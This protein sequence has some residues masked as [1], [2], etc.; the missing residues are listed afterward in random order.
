[1]WRNMFTIKENKRKR[2]TEWK[3]E[4]NA[5]LRMETNVADRK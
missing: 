4:R 2:N 3:G 1:M 5:E